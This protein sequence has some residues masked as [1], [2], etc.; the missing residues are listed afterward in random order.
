MGLELPGSASLG[1]HP[2]S[3][4]PAREWMNEMHKLAETVY[5]SKRELKLYRFFFSPKNSPCKTRTIGTFDEFAK[6]KSP[7]ILYFKCPKL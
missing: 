4:E 1:L 6:S 3:E 5:E 7:N 2:H